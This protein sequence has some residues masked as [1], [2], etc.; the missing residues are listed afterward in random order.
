MLRALELATMGIG[1]VSPNPMV[2]C[3]IVKNDKI[4]GEGWHERY[5]GPHAEVNAINS[6]KDLAFLSGA[7]MFVTLEPCSHYGKTPPCADLII[8]F[9]FKKVWICNDD[10]NP[11]VNGKGKE[12]L[13]QSNIEVHTGLLEK[14]GKIINKRFFTSIDKKRPYI[15]LKWAQTQDGFIA[16]ENFDSKWISNE[17]SRRLSHKWRAEEDAILVGKNTAKYDNP[18]LNVRTWIGRDPIRIVL[19]NYLELSETLH[20]FDRSIPTIIV[21]GK[22]NDTWGNLSYMLV[23]R[24][25]NFIKTLMEQL[26]EQKMQS[27][28][29]EGGSMVLNEFIQSSYWDEARIFTSDICFGKGIAAPHIQGEIVGK[30]AILTDDLTVV[31]N[32]MLL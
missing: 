26:S 4:I 29:V 19:D 25:N 10:P 8:Q 3:V 2:G 27:I 24:G 16:R 9:P 18:R 1:K 7:E 13:I 23:N 17:V 11:L 14:M 28:L 30:D 20:L 6:V 12:K 15:I 21:N 31:K 5:G 22:L 32:S